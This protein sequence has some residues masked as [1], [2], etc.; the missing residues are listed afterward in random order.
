MGVGKS[1]GWLRAGAQSVAQLGNPTTQTH[2]CIPSSPLVP[3]PGLEPWQGQIPCPLLCINSEEFTRSD[4]FARLQNLAKTAPNPP[5]YSVAG[6]THPSFSDVF[7]IVP[8]FIN[9]RTGLKVDADE[10]LD[11]TMEITMAFLT[12]HCGG[13]SQL[14]CEEAA[15]IF[16][17]G[18]TPANAS[19]D[20]LRNVSRSSTPVSMSRSVTPNGGSNPFRTATWKTNRSTRSTRSRGTLVNEMDGPICSKT[21][22]GQPGDINWHPNLSDEQLDAIQHHTPVQGHSQGQAPQR[23][24]SS[25]KY[26]VHR[27]SPLATEQVS[28]SSEKELS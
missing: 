13:V 19:S 16:G 5:I 25:S 21:C 3:P 4:D 28:E 6:S 11:K 10:M 17:T 2:R 8:G 20:S 12:G 1:D 9:R 24:R 15:L 26:D 14:D 7:L 27:M 22:F 23:S 18:D